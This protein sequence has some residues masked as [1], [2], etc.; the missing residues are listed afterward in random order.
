VAKTTIPSRDHQGT[1]RL[2]AQ[3]LAV[4]GFGLVIT[5]MLYELAVSHYGVVHHTAE[6]ER[7]VEDNN[8]KARL[9]TDMGET[10]Q[11]RLALLDAV[12]TSSTP[13]ALATAKASLFDH[14][15]AYLDARAAWSGLDI[16]AT[17]RDVL[18]TIDDANDRIRA[19]TSHLLTIISKYGTDEKTLATAVQTCRKVHLELLAALHYGLRT[20]KE[21]A[22]PLVAAAGEQA[23]SSLLV[24]SGLGMLAF[25]L[26]IATAALVI[27]NTGA[28]IRRLD[29]EAEHDALTDLHNRNAFEAALDALLIRCRQAPESHALLVIGIDRFKIVNETFGHAGGDQLLRGLADLLRSQLRSNGMA[30]R[31]G[32]DEFGV[33]LHT[34]SPRLAEA[35][36]EQI[37]AA[38]AA[39]V[40]EQD[41]HRMPVAASI[42]MV[43]FGDQQ[44]SACELLR[45]ATACCL[46]AKDEGRN[47]VHLATTQSAQIHRRSGERQW[48]NRIQDALQRDRFV[49]HG[50]LI[51]PLRNDLD[52]GRLCLEVLLRLED[53][54]G[55]GL[56][57]PQ[58]F[59]PTAERYHVIND[60]DRWV[61]RNSL[62]WLVDQDAAADRLRININICGLTASDPQ[63]HR[64]VRDLIRDTGAPPE[65][66]CF[67][68][69]ESLGINNLAH[70][71]AL[72]NSLG[73]LGC[74]FALDDFGSGLSSFSQLRHLAV[75]YLKI[76][77]GFV[78]NIERDSVNR[79]MVESMN[80]LGHRLGKLTV[81]EFVAN[82]QIRQIITEI[83][84]DYVQGFALHRPEP[85]ADIGERLRLGADK[86]LEPGQIFVA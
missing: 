56:I 23:R 44:I 74:R 51:H 8:R 39:H 18:S 79:A 9:L 54:G 80:S 73:D 69:T 76:D 41:G 20:V 32:G 5:I 66:L 72:V 59:L 42:G 26:A 33:L 70:A 37:R 67:E 35:Q 53:D 31:L 25:V 48:L 4:V 77:G 29:Y 19:P 65:S 62:E 61:V 84:V 22:P 2:R 68:I 43:T 13:Q 55:L 17:E 75:D 21:A 24:Q 50:Q 82:D 58:Q 11:R 15:H 64:Y 28:Q 52:D 85:L 27:V 38:I 34:V 83:G 45:N 1:R 16:S 12:G 30:S 6:L 47:R 40:F 10:V 86:Q 46:S 60:I 3:T 71:A 14:I 36:A 7:Q 78:Y 81:A 49:L 57:P 63:F